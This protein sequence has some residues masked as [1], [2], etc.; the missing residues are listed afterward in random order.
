M[1]F[2]R[3]Q[4]FAALTILAL[5]GSIFT[6]SY[7][8]DREGSA[9][10][11]LAASQLDQDVAGQPLSGLLCRQTDAASTI[12][13]S[14][15]LGPT[16]FNYDLS[17]TNATGTLCGGVTASLSQGTS[18]LYLGPLLGLVAS[19]LDLPT[20]STDELLLELR[21]TPG[22]SEVG[23]CQ[24]DTVW[25]A[26]QPSGSGGGGFSDTESLTH[27]VSGSG[28]G[29]GGGCVPTTTVDLYVNKHISGVSQGYE[30]SD[31]S[32]RITGNG[33]DIV[34]P[35]DSFTPL[36]EGTYTIEELV[37]EG[38]VK[39]DWRIGWYGQC[40]A[41]S[42]FSTT[43]TI[44]EG[45]IDHGT[46]YCE[47]D[48]QYR[49]GN[50]DHK[51]TEQTALSTQSGALNEDTPTRS[52]ARGRSGERTR[53]ARVSGTSTSTETSSSTRTSTSSTEVNLTEE[54]ENKPSMATTPA[55]SSTTD[56]AADD[57][58]ESKEVD[59]TAQS[60]TLANDQAEIEDGEEDDNETES[61]EA[62][63][64][65]IEEVE[66]QDSEPEEQ[67]VEEDEPKEETTAEADTDE[68]AS[69]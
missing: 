41:G 7:F 52:S 16:D 58:R 55:A 33:F 4:F 5:S 45:N 26:T 35:H 9:G 23:S 19:D 68:E 32:Y 43:I 40:E 62:E 6:V 1:R 50:N 63:E 66:R 29:I 15:N 65:E 14:S 42:D 67:I 30:H 44:D 57:E 11:T 54:T 21:L 59:D 3:L 47:A 18:T 8:F 51:E 38:F 2:V 53:E 20:G 60:D 27:A 28:T 31:F 24:F 22:T 12:L 34:A 61:S 13:Y 64:Q 46:L 48:N 36:P 10:N 39:E 25:S 49:P 17:I 56:E 69:S 37:P